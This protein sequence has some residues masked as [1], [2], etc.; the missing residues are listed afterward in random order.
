[1]AKEDYI[2]KQTGE[3]VQKAIDDALALAPATVETPGL[4][5]ASDKTKLNSL[6]TGDSLESSLG[7]KVDKVTGKGLSTNDYDNSEKSK[8]AS[9]SQDVTDIKAKIPSQAT[10]QNQL[11][12]KDFV[13]SS[14]ATATADF[15]GTYDSLSELQAVT[16]D[17]NDY[18]YVVSTDQS[19]NT[20]YSRYKYNGSA[21]VFEY[22]LNNSSFTAAEW[23]SIQSQITAALVQKLSAL[24]TNQELGQ[25]LS[26]KQD[27][28]P[29]L[30]TIRSGANAGATAY[31]KPASGIPAS[32]MASGVIPEDVV[33]YA[34]QTL[35]DSQKTQ[36]RTNIGAASEEELDAVSRGEY[37]EAWDGVSEPVVAE[38]PSGVQVEY[39]SQTYTGTLAASNDTLG[40]IYLVGTGTT[41][42]YN[43]YRTSRSGVEGSYTYAW[44]QFGSTQMSLSD[45][46]TKTEVS[47]LQ[48]E[49]LKLEN[50]SFAK[51]A[52]AFLSDDT[53]VTWSTGEFE[54]STVSVDSYV[55][56]NDDGR[57]QKVKA[58]VGFTNN[59]FAAIGFYSSEIPSAATFMKNDSVRSYATTGGEE[60]TANVPAGAKLIVVCTRRSVVETPTITLTTGNDSGIK[61][62]VQR[63]SILNGA[64]TAISEKTSGQYIIF[65]TGAVASSGSFT[66]YKIPNFGI[67]YIKAQLNFNDRNPAAF[68]FYSSETV[69]TESYLGGLQANNSE[70]DFWT[71]IPAGCKLIVV[72]N[73]SSALPSP[74]ISLY[75]ENDFNTFAELRKIS[76]GSDSSR[77]LTALESALQVQNKQFLFDGPAYAHLFIENTGQ[78]DSP[79]IPS[80]SLEDV[81]I[82]AR[83]GFKYI[84]AN[85]QVTSDGVLIPIHGDAG[86]FG[87]E[88][89]DTNGE[90]TYADTSIDSVTYE[91]IQEHIRYRSSVTK[92][93]TTIP[94]LEEFMTE[95]RMNGISVMMTYNSASYALAKKYFG[96]N[97]IAYQG[98]RDAG[99]QGIIMTYS[100]LATKAD[101][102]NR[103]KEVGAPYIHMLNTTA[104]STFYNGGTLKELAQAVHE[105][106][107]MLGLAA[108]YQTPVEVAA[109]L[110]AG[111]DVIAS[112]NQVNFQEYGNLTNLSDNNTFSDLVTTGNVAGGILSLTSGQTIAS[113][114]SDI[115]PLGKGVIEIVFNGQLVVR[116]FG[117]SANTNKTFTS[118]GKNT[119]RISTY[120]L[121]QKPVF[122]LEAAM[123]TMIMSLK[124]K[125][126]KC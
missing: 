47:Q 1:M 78:S 104:F 116:G 25:S 44:V 97:F 35:T 111:G 20:V 107:C 82:S 122:S 49:A 74:T 33:K 64:D 67:K 92:L 65:S 19:G 120:F 38:I 110:E 125:V 75:C 17:N 18:G 100:D 123:A 87:Y 89:T 102:V 90:F 4:M 126:S 13:N 40:K 26:G 94:T 60:F 2:L 50:V 103:C 54:R 105:T 112:N 23:A 11:A 98:K 99:F 72:S 80:Q 7:G 115:I 88:V 37:V 42:E 121:D 5:S 77:R 27:I 95:C 93:Q 118:S 108:C 30:S 84:E 15:K 96:D 24:P 52:L 124:Y 46:A 91:W 109:F 14:I 62:T 32:D 69:S 43:R 73:R 66:L 61:T 68:A 70:L 85:V 31:Q 53:Q 28:I 81:R 101:I 39:N 79:I 48:Q 16:A 36:A 10:A 59:Q 83:L 51:T 3:Q 57:I 34:S 29:D 6:P 76:G 45:Y 119:V 55:V 21:W 63:L 12:D 117:H 86:K 71:A 58:T 41:N 8:V 113:P 56:I 22:D 106:G 9:A 114:D